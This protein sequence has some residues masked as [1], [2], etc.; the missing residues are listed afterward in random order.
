MDNGRG[1]SNVEMEEEVKFKITVSVDQCKTEGDNF[2]SFAIE[3]SSVI[4]L[5]VVSEIS[6][7][8][9]FQKTKR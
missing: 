6:T 3:V 2:Y 1:C 8:L 4:I 9:S 5:C 7:R